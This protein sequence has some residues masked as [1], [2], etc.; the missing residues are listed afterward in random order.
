L[1]E[2]YQDSIKIQ[3]LQTANELRVKAQLFPRTSPLFRVGLG[4]VQENLSFE[5]KEQLQE[6]FD[7]ENTK[8]SIE[9]ILSAQVCV[10]SLFYVPTSKEII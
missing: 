2:V 3:T 6:D 5:A 9:T 7:K 1:H 8:M 10:S 4:K